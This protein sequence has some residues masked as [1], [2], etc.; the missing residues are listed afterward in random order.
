MSDRIRIRWPELGQEVTATLAL[1]DNPE[2]CEEFLARLP[3]AVIQSHPVVSGSSITCW[4]PY[5]STAPMP[6]TE[7]ITDA[8]PGR[9]RFSQATGSKISIQYGRGLEPMA[10]GVLGQVDPDGVTVLPEIGRR[11]WNNLYW[12][13]ERITVEF[14]HL[15]S[16]AT[17][18][19]DAIDHTL[20]ARLADAAQRIVL[21]EP[22][23][24]RRIRTG[25]VADAGSFG[26][27]FS[28]W[29]AAHG[30]I[31]DYVVQ[32]LFPLYSGLG[33]EPLSLVR[34]AYGLLGT[35]YHATLRFHGYVELADL[36]AEFAEF[37]GTCDEPD[38][39]ELVFRHF[40]DYA[41]RVYSWSHEKFPWYL[42]M[43]FPKDSNLDA[44]GGRWMP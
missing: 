36:A 2:L 7:S 14:E 38:E 26:Q 25:E 22:A 31:R 44:P 6:V 28:V 23:D 15:S 3:F 19:P 39:I 21:D 35:R 10:Q 27:Y 32:T 18:Q 33:K 37:L 4:V 13:K 5:F 29:D 20:A 40:L 9:L 12:E 1:G 24:I 41:N 42:G 8:P 30:L 16:S 11:V 34:G 43:H 17:S